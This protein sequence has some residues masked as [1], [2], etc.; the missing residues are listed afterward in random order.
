MNSAIILVLLATLLNQTISVA[1]NI[2][3]F[4]IRIIL[5]FNIFRS[6]PKSLGNYK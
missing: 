5:W 6:T 2:I 4:S 1:G 3:F